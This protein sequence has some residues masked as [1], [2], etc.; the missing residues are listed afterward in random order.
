ME[1]RI[2]TS[3]KAFLLL[4][5][6]VAII[7]FTQWGSQTLKQLLGLLLQTPF[8]EITFLNPIIGIIAIGGSVMLILG[9]LLRWKGA[10]S[11]RWYFSLGFLLFVFKG[12]FV[13]ANDIMI[14]K[15]TTK[16]LTETHIEELASGISNELLFIT[17]WL[18]LLFYIS[19]KYATVPPKK[20][21]N[22]KTSLT[23]KKIPDSE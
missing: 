21:P 22:K 14:T 9:S 19:K 18:A 1:Q 16:K 10:S 5:I 23:V 4:I 8:T 2:Q 7:Q 20:D 12:M 13:I 15:Q 11:A 17:V 6:I 3:E